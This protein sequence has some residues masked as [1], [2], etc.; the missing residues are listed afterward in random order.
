MSLVFVQLSFRHFPLLFTFVNFLL[1]LF[2]A[3]HPR[4]NMGD[5]VLSI[6]GGGVD[7]RDGG[8]GL[9]LGNRLFVSQLAFFF[10]FFF[11]FPTF[12]VRW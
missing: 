4:G 11:F 6:C 5:M 3:R 12:L 8:F 7:G 9:W 2:S 10:F 1:T